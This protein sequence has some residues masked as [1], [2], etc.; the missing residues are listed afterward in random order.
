MGR[1]KGSKNKKPTID[2]LHTVMT[3]EERLD[4]L[5]RLIVE[6]IE[7][8]QTSGRKLLERIGVQDEQELA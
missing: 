3:S 8:D 1:R 2:P 5:A 7:E 6:H 4:F